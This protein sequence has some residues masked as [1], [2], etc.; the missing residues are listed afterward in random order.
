MDLNYILKRE[1]IS[2]ERAISSRSLCARAVHRELAKAY[3]RLLASSAFPHNA[4]QTDAERTVLRGRR[5]RVERAVEA[6]E[7]EGGSTAF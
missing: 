5:Y 1:Q 2:L 7:S 4:L 6:W 3:G